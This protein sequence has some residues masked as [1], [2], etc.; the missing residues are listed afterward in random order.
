MKKAK[1]PNIL[2]EVVGEPTKGR[3]LNESEEKVVK[4]NNKKKIIKK[5]EQVN[6]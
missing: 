3:I 1:N 2:K 5:K 4:R 6:G